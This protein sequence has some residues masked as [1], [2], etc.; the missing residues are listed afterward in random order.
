VH[1]DR[2]RLKQVLLNLASNAVKF[3]TQG[4][5]VLVSCRHVPGDRLRIAVTDAGPGIPA[6]MMGRLF[7]PFDRLGATASNVEGT[8]LGLALSKRLVDVM[9]GTIGVESVVGR[10]ST[11]WVELPQTEPPPEHLAPPNA[12]EALATAE[13]QP[14][15]TVLYIEDNLANLRL[16][17]RVVA[18]RPSVRL[19]TAIQGRVGLE[20]ARQHHPDLILLDLHLPDISGQEVLQRLRQDPQT[21]GIPVMVISADATPGQIERLLDAGAQEFLT[22][23]FDVRKLLSLIDDVLQVKR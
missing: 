22:K 12:G 5:S 23:P 2:Q 19:L 1:A 11:F 6:E 15:G 3:S 13:Y 7:T 21:D 9:G 17:Q 10:G 4:Q 16:M 20:L 18:R 14:T 8:G